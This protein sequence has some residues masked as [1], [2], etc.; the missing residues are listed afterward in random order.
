M[1]EVDPDRA[2]VLIADALRAC[3]GNVRGVARL[4]VVSRRTVMRWIER[5]NL[6]GVAELERQ[7]RRRQ[8]KD[9]LSG[10]RRALLG[11]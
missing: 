1:F 10:A 8:K 11:G 4:F 3:H 5:A 7:R 6:K 2:R 9:W